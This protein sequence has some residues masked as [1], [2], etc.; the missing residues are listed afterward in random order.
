RKCRSYFLSQ[1]TSINSPK[2]LVVC[3]QR[4]VANSLAGLPHATDYIAECHG[5]LALVKAQGLQ[6]VIQLELLHRV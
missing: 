4:W 3:S 6:F 1:S 2:P 5:N